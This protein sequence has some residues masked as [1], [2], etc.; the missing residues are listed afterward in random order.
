M[1]DVVYG[2]LTPPAD[3]PTL[4]EFL[5]AGLTIMRY[6]EI[7]LKWPELDERQRRRVIVYVAALQGLREGK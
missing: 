2:D 4:D 6:S 1:T 7:L 5:Q 3:M